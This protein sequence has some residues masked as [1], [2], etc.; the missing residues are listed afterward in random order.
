MKKAKARKTHFGIEGT[1]KIRNYERENA[2]KRKRKCLTNPSGTFKVLVIFARQVC[3]SSD[4][5]KKMVKKRAEKRN[6]GINVCY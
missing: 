4:R 3:L 1:M 2:E 6:F 5:Q